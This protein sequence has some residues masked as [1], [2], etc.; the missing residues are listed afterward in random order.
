MKPK[1]IIPYI[2]GEPYIGEAPVG[3]AILVKTM[4]KNGFTAEQ[5]AAATDKDVEEVE[6]ILA[7]GEPVFA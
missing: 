5:I 3:E 6:A 2:E 7:G 4:N 1:E